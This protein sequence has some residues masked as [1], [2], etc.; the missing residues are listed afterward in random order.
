[1]TA[2]TSDELDILARVGAR[3]RRWV[4]MRGVWPRSPQLHCQAAEE[5]DGSATQQMQPFPALHQK[6]GEK[7]RLE[8]LQ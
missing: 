5:I 3:G 8:D 1:M 2:R 7:I 4:K 6:V